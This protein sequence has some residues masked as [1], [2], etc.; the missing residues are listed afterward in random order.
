VSALD[1]SI[2]AQIVNLFAE[3]RERLGLA[4]LFISHDIAVMAHLADRIAIMYLGRIMEIAPAAELIQRPAHPYTVAL[5]SAVPS[6]DPDD[7]RRRQVL[8]GDL[9]SP[10]NPPSGCVFR[11]RCPHALPDCARTVPMLRDVAPGHAKACIRDDIGL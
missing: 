4:L 2:Q 6:P 9:P 10:A 7:H 3:L 5:L 11:T 1:V 8:A